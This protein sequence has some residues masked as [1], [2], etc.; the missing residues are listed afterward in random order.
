MTCRLG[1]RLDLSFLGQET[2]IKPVYLVFP[3]VVT[4]LMPWRHSVKSQEV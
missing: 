4:V 1:V 2:S 3:S